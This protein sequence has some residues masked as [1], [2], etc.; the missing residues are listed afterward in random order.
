MSMHFNRQKCHGILIVKMIYM[1]YLFIFWHTIQ[2]LVEDGSTN[3]MMESINLFGQMCD[4]P[5]FT[6]TNMILFLNKKDLFA[7]KLK[8][9]P[10]TVT[11]PDYTGPNRY[12]GNY[13]HK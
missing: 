3:R 11:F 4:H 10:L 9:R 12:K 7:D 13:F 6:E 2:V 5:C 8:I 1:Y